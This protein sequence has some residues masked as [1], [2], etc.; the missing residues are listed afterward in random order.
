LSGAAEGPQPL[1]SKA[2]SSRPL[3]S[4]ESFIIIA[5]PLA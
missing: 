4:K 2:V 1:S 3:P 5:I